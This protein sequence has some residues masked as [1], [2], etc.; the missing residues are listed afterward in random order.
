MTKIG[1][2]LYSNKIAGVENYLA[3]LINSWPNKNHKIYVFI[4][5]NFKHSLRLKK[6]FTRKAEILYYQDIFNSNFK[7]EKNLVSRFINKI[8][9]FFTIFF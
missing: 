6:L 8:N 2:F 1:F 3:N 9:F 4:N 7:S 5:H